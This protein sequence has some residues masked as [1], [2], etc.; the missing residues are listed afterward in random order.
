MEVPMRVLEFL[1]DL[2]GAQRLERFERLERTD[3]YDE[4]P[5]PGRSGTR[6]ALEL[7]NRWNRMSPNGA[8]VYQLTVRSGFWQTNDSIRLLTKTV[9]ISAQKIED[10]ARS[11]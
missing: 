11:F 4:R 10:C 9:W 2:N 8:K 5:H 6:A 1:N 3:P 7:W